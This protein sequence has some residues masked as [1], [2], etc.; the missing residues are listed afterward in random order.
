MQ[1]RPFQLTLVGGVG[2]LAT[3]AWTVGSGVVHVA[4]AVTALLVP[5]LFVIAGLLGPL[6]KAASFTCALL[7]G[8]GALHL[9]ALAASALALVETPGTAVWHTISQVLFVGGLALLLPLA[10]GYPAGPGPRWAWIVVAAASLIPVV[11]AFSG[12]TPTVLSATDATGAMLQLGPVA[13][14]LPAGLAAGAGIVFLMPAAAAGIAVV[15]LVRGDR[16]L[17]GRL[18]LPLGALG[19]FAV[20]VMLGSIVPPSAAG[21]GTALFLVSAP[22]LPVGLIAGSRPIVLDP[23]DVESRRVLRVHESSGDRLETLSPR[24]REVLALMADGHS[25][26]AIGRALHISLSAVEKHATSIFAKLGVARE[27]DTHRRVAA[28]VAYLRAVSR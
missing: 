12:A 1:R 11:T 21:V 17:R 14:V 5:G 3:T 16:E 2:A 27:A 26:P 28:V 8:I 7:V 10:A 18:I 19:G 15:R 4:D 20:V 24:E 25:N 13:A 23:A 6:W 9:F 22:L